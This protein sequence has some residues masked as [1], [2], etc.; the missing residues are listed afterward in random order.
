MNSD[1]TVLDLTLIQ[2]TRKSSASIFYFL[3]NFLEYI[4]NLSILDT[5]IDKKRKYS[6]VAH[7]VAHWNAFPM[8]T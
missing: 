4:L 7:L 3:T 1:G 8:S 6:S 2:E 5:I